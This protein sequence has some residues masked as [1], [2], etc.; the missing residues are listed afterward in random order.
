MAFI[1]QA[2]EQ[3]IAESVVGGIY[4]DN[5]NSG[6][7]VS[8][9]TALSLGNATDV[10]NAKAAGISSAALGS[11]FVPTP[12]SNGYPTRRIVGLAMGSTYSGEAISVVNKGIFIA[13]SGAAITADALL[14]PSSV[15]SIANTAQP[16]TT[17]PRMLL[18]VMKLPNG[19]PLLT[20]N[21]GL[22][23]ATAITPTT[24]A[25]TNVLYYPLGYA[26]TTTTALYDLVVVQLECAPFYA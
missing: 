11:L 9:F 14:F 25:G 10:T 24:G 2:W 23:E 4:Y 26:Y 6:Q 22:V 3:P 8:A 19:T 15:A 20:Y 21:V 13:I 1:R 16:F 7:P 17:V 5:I 18:Q 12:I